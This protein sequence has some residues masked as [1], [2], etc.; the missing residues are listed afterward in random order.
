MITLNGYGR[1]SLGSRLANYVEEHCS[2]PYGKNK[3]ALLPDTGEAT[4]EIGE[5]L[6]RAFG[7]AT[8][9]D[10]GEIAYWRVPRSMIDES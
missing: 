8:T 5:A 6:D 4:E 1:E 2:A 10:R 3:S 9:I 7:R